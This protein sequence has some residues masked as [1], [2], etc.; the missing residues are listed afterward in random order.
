VS[1]KLRR[2][3]V[4]VTVCSSDYVSSNGRMN[5]EFERMWKEADMAQPVL[6]FE[7]RN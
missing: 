4:N 5:S 6:A 3:S 2:E 7:W 1:G